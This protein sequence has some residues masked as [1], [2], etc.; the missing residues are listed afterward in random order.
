MGPPPP[1]G[2][3]NM[4]GAQSPDGMGSPLSGMPPSG[5]MRSPLSR[6]NS[7]PQLMSGPG[8]PEGHSPGQM[9]IPTS[10]NQPGMPPRLHHPGQDPYAQQVP[11]PRMMEMPGGARPQFPPGSR[12]PEHMLQGGPRPPEP[13]GHPGMQRP[14]GPYGQ[15]SPGQMPPSPFR[16]AS[17]GPQPPRSAADPFGAT[18][19]YAHPPGTPIP[20]MPSPHQS[21]SKPQ[22]PGAPQ[23]ADPYEQPVPTPRSMA[24][25][26]H[27]SSAPHTPTTQSFDPFSMPG[28]RGMHPHNMPHPPLARQ[29]SVPGDPYAQPPGTPRQEDPYAFS[30]STPGPAESYSPR[31]VGPEGYMQGPMGGERFPRPPG[32]Q[33]SMSQP[34]M[35][36]MD[37]AMRPRFRAPN[38]P[39]SRGPVP[40][41]YLD[42]RMQ[43]PGGPMMG[44]DQKEP[45]VVSA[46]S[47]IRMDMCLNVSPQLLSRNCV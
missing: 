38:P 16:G 41:G 3:G 25:G 47:K 15:H 11:T 8:T 5:D 1:P 23:E 35:P 37:P 10:P 6:S 22:W 17:G 14:P 32:L 30:P 34:G 46:E 19:P 24:E 18:D 27:S 29:T 33:R 36:G 45:S 39:M 43:Q 40:G 2:Q 26:I 42:P 7:N 44:M 12:P 13:Y 4:Y 21:P 20:G 9:Q 31:A 28:P